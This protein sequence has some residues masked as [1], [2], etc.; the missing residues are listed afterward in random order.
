MSLRTQI[1]LLAL[2]LACVFILYLFTKGGSRELGN[3][4]NTSQRQM[5]SSLSESIR[6]GKVPLP[7][8]TDETKAKLDASKGFQHLVSYTDGGFE[9]RAL[10]MSRGE[11]VRF[12]NNSSMNLWIAADGSE[13]QI[14]PRTKEVCGSSDLDSCEPFMPQD[15]WEFTFENAGTWGIVNNLDKAKSGIIIVE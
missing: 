13:V 6:E 2:L 9:P 3:A 5:E 11:S 14:Y 1:G 10:A 12:T 7:E 15:F 4:S 8:F